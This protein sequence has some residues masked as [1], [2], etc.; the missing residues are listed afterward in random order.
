[1]PVYKY[2]KKCRLPRCRGDFETNREWREFCHP[3]HQVEFQKL[4]RR[5][6]DDLI[7]ELELLKEA[8]KKAAKDFD[9]FKMEFERLEDRI[10][11]SIDID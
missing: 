4:L 3:H 8:A 11:A 7:V 6:H 10:R 9:E 5:S 1:M 2:E